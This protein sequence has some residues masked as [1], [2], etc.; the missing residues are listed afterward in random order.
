MVTIHP[1]III[2]SS[3]LL[4]LLVIQA[5]RYLQERELLLS[6]TKPNR[7]AASEIEMVFMLLKKNILAQYI[8]HDLYLINKN[9]TYT[10]IDIVLVTNIGIIVIEVKDYSGWIFGTGNQTYWTQVLAYGQQ[11]YKFYNPILQ[12]KKHIDD[13]KIQLAQYE[14]IPFYSI[15]VFFGSCEFQNITAIPSNVHLIKAWEVMNVID[16]II[17][18][19]PTIKYINKQE[20]LDTLKAAVFNGSDKR[21]RKKHIENI[22]IMRSKYGLD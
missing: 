2:I 21:I 17:Q 13:L 10:Q 7:A 22:E 4:S 14:N 19:N 3:L 12:N 16:N 6:V 9:G 5:I 8:F 1:I 20:I 11:K 15:V 18:D